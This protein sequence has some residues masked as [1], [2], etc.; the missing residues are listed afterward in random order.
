MGVLSPVPM[1]PSGRKHL[2]LCLLTNRRTCHVV[3]VVNPCYC[4]SS[5]TGVANEKRD[6]EICCIID[7]CQSLERKTDI[8]SLHVSRESC[9]NASDSLPSETWHH[10]LLGSYTKIPTAQRQTRKKQ[11]YPAHCRID[12]VKTFP[13]QFSP[14]LTRTISLISR[15]TTCAQ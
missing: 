13:I 1:H 5:E 12:I 9:E 10:E 11:A 4:G 8:C 2:G 3:T 15:Q 6:V 7:W 14:S